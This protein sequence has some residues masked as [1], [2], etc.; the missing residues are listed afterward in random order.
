C[1]SGAWK[2]SEALQRNR[3]TW[4]Y[5]YGGGQQFMSC[6]VGQYMS[7]FSRYLENDWPRTG[8]FQIE[9]CE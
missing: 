8:H 7:G 1:Q 9:C 6:P 4:Y 5:I 3:C 2:K